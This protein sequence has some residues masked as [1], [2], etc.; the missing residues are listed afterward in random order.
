MADA[1]RVVYGRTCSVEER[2]SYSARV[3]GGL[4]RALCAME[5][6][7][8]FLCAFYESILAAG[9]RRNHKHLYAFKIELIDE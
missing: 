8:D 4:E 2:L 9:P 1:L 7:W 3:S 5:G 6:R